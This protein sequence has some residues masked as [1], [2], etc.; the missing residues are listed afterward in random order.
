MRAPIT[1]QTHIHA[2]RDS[3]RDL[4]PLSPDTQ[5]LNTQP[6]SHHRKLGLALIFLAGFIQASLGPNYFLTPNAPASD[7]GKRT[8]IIRA[9]VPAGTDTVYLVGNR[10]EL[11]NWNPHILAMKG[12][13][14]NRTAS[15][16]LPAGTKLEFKF[17][18]G[19]WEREGL[20]PSG[21]TGPNNLLTVETNTEVT[22]VIPGFKKEI[23]DSPDDWKGSGVLGRLEYWKRVPSNFLT[24]TRTMGKTFSTHALPTPAWTGAWMKPSCAV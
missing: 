7:E 14:T 11:G 2:G 23:A 1:R 9:Q 8:I 12:D 24:A 22:V 10:P 4:L 18:L 16:R 21:I 5:L 17:T 20:A 13:G 3:V 15:L 6:S 19:S